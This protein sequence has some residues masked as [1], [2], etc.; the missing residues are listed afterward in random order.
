M[1]ENGHHPTVFDSDQQ[2]LGSTYAKALLG[3]TEKRGTTDEVLE[4]FRSAVEDVFDKLPNFDAVLSSPR[5]PLEE[6]ERLL[7]RAFAGKMNRDLL[8]FFKVVA[9]HG[10]FNVL[11]AIEVEFVKQY[12][13]LRGRVE[14]SVETATP[15]NDA[16]RQEILDRLKSTLQR[17]VQLRARVNPD[18]VG[19]LVIRIGD[20]VYDGSVLN[21]LHRFGEAAM[22][23]TRNAFRE[24]LDRFAPVA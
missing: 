16:L 9:S 10:R 14:V 13:A 23:R 6:K 11:R 24:S 2:Y 19:G 20:T 21:Q 22:S 8:N 1:T 3:V 7:D 4:Q 15:L 17:D 5:I 18:I 12:N